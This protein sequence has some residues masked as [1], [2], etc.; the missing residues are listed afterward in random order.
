MCWG[1][2]GGR[3]PPRLDGW[4][5]SPPDLLVREFYHRGRV[6]RP[7]GSSSSCSRWV[8]AAGDLAGRPV[9]PSSN[10][11]CP[12]PTRAHPYPGAI[13]G[14]PSSAAAPAR[15]QWLSS[16]PPPR[17]RPSPAPAC[18]PARARVCLASALPCPRPR[19]FRR[20]ELPRSGSSAPFRGHL[21]TMISKKDAQAELK[22]AKS[23]PKSKTNR[24]PNPD[25][26]N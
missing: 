17:Q 19:R 14:P 20:S 12:R 21:P 4:T 7:T 15:R 1:A 26:N 24:T 23:S 16:A 11:V 3:S 2:G 5:A 18:A 9:R 22:Q 25:V 6:A 13:H 10:S 8:C